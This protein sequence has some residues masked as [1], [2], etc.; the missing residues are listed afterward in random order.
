[1]IELSIP[2]ATDGAALHALIANSPPLDPN[3]LYCNLLHCSHFANT[4][5]RARMDGELVGFISGYMIPERPDTLFVWQVVV[6]GKARGQG[7]GRRMLEALVDRTGARY[8]ETTITADNEASWA[9]FKSLA[10]HRQTAGETS[11]MFDRDAHF[12]GQHDSEHLFRI[13]PFAA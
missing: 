2:D 8:M 10:R 9:L 12:K 7:L 11:V 6:S 4:S 13:G 3:S 1:M 5:V